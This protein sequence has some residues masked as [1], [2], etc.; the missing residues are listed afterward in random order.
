METSDIVQIVSVC[1]TVLGFIAS[2]I[3]ALCPGVKANGLLH[4]L[5]LWASDSTDVVVTLPDGS[6]HNTY[7]FRRRRTLYGDRLGIHHITPAPSP[8]RDLDHDSETTL[9]NHV[10]GED[11]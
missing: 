6:G 2:E 1:V 10:S 5:T 7:E 4:W 9:Q 3:M 8:S 11:Q